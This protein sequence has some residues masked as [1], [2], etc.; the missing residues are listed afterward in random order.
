MLTVGAV[1]MCPPKK[2]VNL[3]CLSEAKHLQQLQ[4]KRDF[5]GQSP[6]HPVSLRIEKTK[7]YNSK[8]II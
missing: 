6:Q 3:S 2:T 1:P 5:F 8:L 7:F 4:K